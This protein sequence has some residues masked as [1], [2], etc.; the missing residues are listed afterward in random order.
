ML[1][2]ALDDIRA[3][4][5]RIDGRVLRT[6]VR[7]SEWLSAHCGA[8][9]Y[10]KLEVVQPTS[11]YKVRGAFNAAL[12]IH[13]RGAGAAPRL[14]TA[15]AGN[16]GR[17]LAP[18]RAVGPPLTVF[19]EANATRAKATHPGR[20]RRAAQCAD[21]DE[22]RAAGKVQ[23][24]RRAA[25]NLYMFAPDGIAGAG[26]CVELLEDLRRSTGDS[27]SAAAG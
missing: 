10:L 22:A 15:S 18:P 25:S 13:E 1:P 27:L 9:V 7:Q 12:V 19:I 4:S 24:G 20:R 17:A 21:Y 26:T 2:V 16:H 5:R 6:P 3:A 11:S 14:V 23:P 8:G